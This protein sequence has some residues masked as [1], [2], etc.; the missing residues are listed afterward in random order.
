M[1]Q[2]VRP[3]SMSIIKTIRTDGF[4]VCDRVF[5]LNSNFGA[6]DGFAGKTA[7]LANLVGDNTITL[8]V[9]GEVTAGVC[10]ST[11]ALGLADLAHDNLADADFLAT[12]QLNTEALALA[13]AGIFAGTACFDV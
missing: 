9:D 6:A 11:S 4:Y 1:G 8:S 12:E 10:A 7:N 3:I 2:R 13:V 5:L